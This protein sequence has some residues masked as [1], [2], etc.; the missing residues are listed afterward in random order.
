MSASEKAKN[1]VSEIYTKLSKKFGAAVVRTFLYATAATVMGFGLYTAFKFVR[2][3]VL[4]LV[5]S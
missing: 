5:F 4:L 2:V 3:R 1:H